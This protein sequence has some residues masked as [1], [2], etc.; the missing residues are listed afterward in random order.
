MGVGRQAPR[1]SGVPAGGQD[2]AHCC[3]GQ[4]V[5]GTIMGLMSAL[6]F[7][8][9]GNM[10]WVSSLKEQNAGLNLGLIQMRQC[11]GSN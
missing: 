6:Q 4:C 1:R 9:K 8:I 11:Q 5:S 3:S 2:W 7:P 10:P